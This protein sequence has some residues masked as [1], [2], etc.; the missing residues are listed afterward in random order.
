MIEKPKT[1][2]KL[3]PIFARKPLP[4]M[5]IANIT[6]QGTIITRSGREIG[7]PPEI[8]T[9]TNRICKADIRKMS[10]WLIHEAIREA[11]YR[12]DDFNLVC[13]EYTNPDK[14]TTSD[15]DM[16]NEYLFGV[17]DVAELLR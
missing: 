17:T 5:S 14:M 15:Y 8:R 3:R 13:F 10:R 1:I 16:T 9:T 6:L 11:I 4:L 12:D 2:E 7:M